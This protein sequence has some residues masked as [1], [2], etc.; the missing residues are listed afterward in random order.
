MANTLL[1][2]L[3]ELDRMLAD[4]DE[5]GPGLPWGSAEQRSIGVFARLRGRI[6]PDQTTWVGRG[7]NS[8]GARLAWLWHHFFFQL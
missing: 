6:D 5:E 3:D 7:L 1:D 8:A 4:A 2:K